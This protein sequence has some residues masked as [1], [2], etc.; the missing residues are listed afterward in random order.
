MPPARPDAIARLSALFA[1]GLGRVLGFGLA[2]SLVLLL[3]AF[4]V[5]AARAAVTRSPAYRISPAAVAFVDLPVHVDPT[6]REAL[7]EGLR[8][9]WPAQP[10][11]LPNVFHADLDR[12]VRSLVA[13]HPMV[14]EVADVDVRFPGEVRVR[15]TVRTPLARFEARLADPRRGAPPQRVV[16]P[17]DGEAVVLDPVVYADFLGAHRTVLVT[18]VE[19]LCP[20]VGRR[21][22][23]GRDQVAEGLF[24][25]KT[26]HRWNAETLGRSLPRV[27]VVDVAGFPASPRTR[28]RGEV[29]FVLSDGRTVQWG[30]T[31]RD[32]AGVT[33]EDPYGVKRDRLIDLLRTR[34]A[35][36]RRPLDVRFPPALRDLS[37][38]PDPSDGTR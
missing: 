22:V 29:V 21:F 16:V 19:T 30:R 36:D 23:D 18:G 31:E 12:R 11:A 25:A 17:V 6:M 37:I 7:R 34:P 4:A 33:R 26:A 38:R 9:I 15:A 35:A 28:M 3:S 32:L 13:A 8:S 20:G 5:R 2:A 1:T 14:R 10:S 27:D 24:A